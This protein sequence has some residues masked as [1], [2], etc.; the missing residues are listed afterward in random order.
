MSNTDFMDMVVFGFP[1]DE[2]SG[3]TIAEELSHERQSRIYRSAIKGTVEGI[4]QP[5]GSKIGS[6]Q[7]QPFWAIV[8]G[9]G[10]QLKL[11]SWSGQRQAMELFPKLYIRDLLD[12]WKCGPEIDGLISRIRQNTLAP[13]AE[14]IAQRLNH[15][16]KMSE[17]EE[18]DSCVVSSDSLRSFERFSNIYPRMRYPDITLTPGGDVYAR[19]KGSNRSLLSIQFLPEMRVRFVVF[20]PNQRHPEELNRA[21]GNDFVDTVIDNLSRAY[22]VSNWVLE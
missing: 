21:S 12:S 13:N 5:S 7:G 14:L 2:P 16:W 15:L 9:L 4:E 17:V 10:E 3:S 8:T 1:L 19:W 20:A 11:S 18:T 22:G 6:G